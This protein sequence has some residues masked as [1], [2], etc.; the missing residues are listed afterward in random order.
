MQ[1]QS[2]AMTI[3]QNEGTELMDKESLSWQTEII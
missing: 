3:Q 2:V 1:I